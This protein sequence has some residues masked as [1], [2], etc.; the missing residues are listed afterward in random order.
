MG[1]FSGILLCTDLDDTLLTTDKRVSDENKEAIEYFKK[2]GGAF[3]FATGRVPLGAKPIIEQV[4]PNAPSVCFNG[5]VIY[6]FVNREM[7]WSKAID[8]GA[9]KMVEFVEKNFPTAGIEVCTADKVYFCKVNRLVERHRQIERFPDNYGDYHDI[10][11]DWCKVIFMV[12][13]EE[14]AE[15]RELIDNCEYAK[16]YS[17]VRSSPWYYELLPYGAHKGSGLIRLGEL[18]GIKKENIYAMGDNENDLELVRAA[19]T[20]IAVANAAKCVKD[21]SDYITTADNNSHAAKEVIEM[22]ESRLGR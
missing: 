21:A 17:F 6:D 3:A 11:E 4:M 22:I 16:N 19:G 2:E 12:E 1:K 9:V 5:S 14:M 15:L 10:D 7:L 8:K 18:M 20:G 13:E